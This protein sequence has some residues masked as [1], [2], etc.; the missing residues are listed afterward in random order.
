MISVAE[1]LAKV[2]QDKNLPGNKGCITAVPMQ[3][4]LYSD[5][6]N[7]KAKPNHTLKSG[8]DPTS[9]AYTQVPTHFGDHWPHPPAPSP[10]VFNMSMSVSDGTSFRST[11]YDMR[12]PIKDVLTNQP[13]RR[14]V[15]KVWS[16]DYSRDCRNR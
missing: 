15:V 8:H 3:A 6:F 7:G 10:K 1:Q 2:N 12:P 14:T 16:S 5:L 11:C 9:L 13:F 4:F